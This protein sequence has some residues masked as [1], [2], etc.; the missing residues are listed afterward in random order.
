MCIGGLSIVDDESVPLRAAT[1]RRGMWLSGLPDVSACPLPLDRS[2][3]ITPRRL[4]MKT[5]LTA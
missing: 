5:F 3:H 1:E 2:S 4:L